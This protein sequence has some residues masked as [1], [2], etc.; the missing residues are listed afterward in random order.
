MDT[1]S[2]REEREDE[3]RCFVLYAIVELWQYK[4]R[5]RRRGSQ[6]KFNTLTGTDMLDLEKSAFVDYG[7]PVW[8]YRLS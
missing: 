1:T 7:V 4:L 3:G 5:A 6:E 8:K 2:S